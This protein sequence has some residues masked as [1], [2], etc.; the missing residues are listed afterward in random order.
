M[1]ISID[2][3]G[4]GRQY[5]L[6]D[7]AAG[8]RIRCKDCRE[9]MAVPEAAVIDEWCDDGDDFGDDDWGHDE[10]GSPHAA[11][12]PSVGG[13]GKLPSARAKKRRRRSRT[14]NG[15]AGKIAGIVAG[16]VVL[17]VLVGVGGQSCWEDE[18]R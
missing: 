8:K 1:T 16:A 4:C 14:G 13:H 7:E 11:A 10:A 17:L 2:C 12:L 5:D 15:N 6:R 3:A 18:F 9:V